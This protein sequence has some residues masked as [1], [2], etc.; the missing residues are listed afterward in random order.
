MNLQNA[1]LRAGFSFVERLIT[2][3]KTPYDARALTLV[4]DAA[5]EWADYVDVVAGKYKKALERN[6]DF[7][8][9]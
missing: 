7:D 8:G 6:P 3:Q 1:E 2:E 5:K 9:L 4:L